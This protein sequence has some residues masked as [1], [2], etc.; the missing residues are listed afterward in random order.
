MGQMIER[1]LAEYVN[2]KL[3]PLELAPREGRVD[4]TTLQAEFEKTSKAI[5]AMGEALACLARAN[6]ETS[7]YIREA[8]EYVAKLAEHY[9]REGEKVAKDIADRRAIAE[10]ARRQCDSLMQQINGATRE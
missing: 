7:H 5:A 9:T 2:G 8:V 4:E 6:D 1:E 10:E 3:P